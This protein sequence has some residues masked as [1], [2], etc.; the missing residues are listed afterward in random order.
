MTHTRGYRI[1]KSPKIAPT[2]PGEILR[3][4]VLPALGTSVTEAARALRISRQTLHRLLAVVAG[5]ALA[6]DA[7]LAAEQLAIDVT[8]N[9]VVGGSANQRFAQVF[10]LYDTGYVSHI[11]LPLGCQPQATVVVAIEETT[12]GVPNGT[13]LAQKVTLGYVLDAYPTASG[14][15]GMRMVEFAK[16][17][18]LKPGTYVFTVSTE[19]KYDCVFWHGPAGNSY[20]AGDAYFIAA[21]N[22]PGWYPLGRDLAF[23]VYQRPL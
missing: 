12:R 14:A 8:S 6:V 11:M 23:Q 9:T 20:S 7:E 4:D 2:H 3:E 21:G 13:V 16:P 19:G 15:V 5:P 1:T 22:P 10:E 18:L 17:A